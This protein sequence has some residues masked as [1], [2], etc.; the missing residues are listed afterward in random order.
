MKTFGRTMP[1]HGLIPGDDR[2][3]E[4]LGWCYKERERERERREEAYWPRPELGKKGE[5]GA[6]MLLGV[7]ELDL[8]EVGVG[9]ERW[10]KRERVPAL[11]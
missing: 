6:S 8:G 10:R 11:K 4:G 1:L 5:T 7:L 3:G 2:A 9:V